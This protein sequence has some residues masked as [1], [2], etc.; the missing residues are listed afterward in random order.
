MRGSSERPQR[1]HATGA[2]RRTRGTVLFGSA[3]LR[4]VSEEFRYL[5]LLAKNSGG[6]CPTLGFGARPAQPPVAI[7]HRSRRGRHRGGGGG[8][9]SDLEPILRS[10]VRTDRSR[11]LNPVRC[12][13]CALLNLGV[14]GWGSNLAIG[15]AQQRRPAR[16]PPRRA[17]GSIP[18]REFLKIPSPT[19]PV[20]R[21]G[22]AR[23]R[24]CGARA[25]LRMRA[26]TASIDTT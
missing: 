22:S 23:R 12:A 24:E 18:G 20:H 5:A 14:I 17:R 1:G 11:H 10:V 19:M 9:S 26:C 4:A 6:V 25:C 3:E 7:E 13:A 15:S 21:R 2:L 8:G 16:R